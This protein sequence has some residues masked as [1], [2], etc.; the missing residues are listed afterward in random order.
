[1][2]A[3]MVMAM[4][5]PQAAP[6]LAA[7]LDIAEAARAKSIAVASPFVLAGGYGAVWLAFSAIAASI[8]IFAGPV[9]D[10]LIAGLFFIAAGVYQFMPLKHACLTKCRQPM[11]YFLSRWTDTRI[12]A[13]G[14]GLELGLNCLG[15]CWAMMLL[16][17]VAGMMNPVWM[18][19]IGGLMILEKILP[20]PRAIIA[21]LGAGLAGAGVAML[22]AN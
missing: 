19:L 2:W 12:G 13:F 20:Q 8:E 21:G 14:M 22:I 17:L 4:M 18:A 6:M 3:V 16:A 9:G 15:C 10:H 5:L 1:M 11:P 7:Y